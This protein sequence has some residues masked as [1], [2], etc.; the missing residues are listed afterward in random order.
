MKIGGWRNQVDELLRPIQSGD[1]DTTLESL[2]TISDDLEAV[3]VAIQPDVD[4][5]QRDDELLSHVLRDTAYKPPANQTLREAIGVRQTERLKLRADQV[6]AAARDAETKATK[7]L[8]DEQVRKVE[9]E[10]EIKRQ[11]IENDRLAAERETARL[12]AVADAEAEAEAARVARAQLESELEKDMRMVQSFLMPFITPAN[13][14]IGEKRYYVTTVTSQPV[15]LSRLR[16]LGALDPTL[17]GLENLYG[18][19]S[20]REGKRPF[21]SFPTPFFSERLRDDSIR[22]KIVIA[23]N[24]LNKYGELLVEKGMLAP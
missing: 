24:L 19:G 17:G 9:A 4:R 15:S 5:L 23:Q 6:A 1:V 13:T 3:A 16:G 8:Q 22:N 18:L 7:Q 10:A 11:M 12:K 20:N 21:G 14:Q 2:Q